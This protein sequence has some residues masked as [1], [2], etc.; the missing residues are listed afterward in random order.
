M[1]PDPFAKDKLQHF[2]AGVIIAAVLY[3]FIGHYALLAAIA[4]GLIKEYVFD[5]LCPWGTPDIWDA[6]ATTLGGLSV[7]L[8]VLI[9]RVI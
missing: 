1:I 7:S 4:I 5:V 9:V 8:I 6:I 2:F 3:P